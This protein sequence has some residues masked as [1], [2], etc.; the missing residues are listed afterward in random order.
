MGTDRHS[1]QMNGCGGAFFLSFSRSFRSVYISP[2]APRGSPTG[3]VT[4]Q[5][6][7]RWA[8]RATGCHDQG[9][10]MSARPG[11]IPCGTL[12]TGPRGQDGRPGLRGASTASGTLA[13]AAREPLLSKPPCG[14]VPG[15]EPS[16]LRRPHVP[17]PRPKPIR[18]I[19]NRGTRAWHPGGGSLTRGSIGARKINRRSR[20]WCCNPRI[21]ALV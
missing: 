15:P 18:N 21:G 14:G 9:R 13:C 1:E 5:L 2:R 17:A 8:P 11:L 12:A 4:K 7:N 10:T 6:G 20:R 19:Q 16:T 3:T